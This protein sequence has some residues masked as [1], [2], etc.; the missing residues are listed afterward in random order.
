MT[1][2][3]AAQFWEDRY[4]DT[5][6]V[7]S[8]RP[9][10]VL[11]DVAAELPV[12]RALDLGCGEGGDAIWLAERGWQVTGVDI[13]STAI[14][15]ARDA[16]SAAGIPA[17][18]IRWHA[19]DLASWTGDDGDGD[20]GYDLVS[21]CFLQSWFDFPRAE[22][23]RNAATLVAPGGHLLVVAHAAPP[24]WADLPDGNGH[25]DHGHG[26]DHL[27]PAPDDELRDLDL[28]ESDW[29]VLVAKTRDRDAHGPDGRRGVLTDGVVLMRRR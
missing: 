6:R 2:T 7:W 21:A 14:G 20:G 13:A 23:L 1:D 17:N 15:R 5:S 25:D 8:G 11:V 27:F 18:R 26:H 4:A 19:Q 28:P 22:I 24:P 29:E 10:Q 3:D 16:A 9:N 12:G